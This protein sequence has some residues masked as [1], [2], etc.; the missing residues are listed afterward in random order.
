MKIKPVS[1]RGVT[2]QICYTDHWG[3][4][5]NS[6]NAHPSWFTFE[7]EEQVRNTKWLIEKGDCVF[8]VGACFGSYTL[9]A[10]AAGAEHVVSW[11]PQAIKGDSL[12][13]GDYLF[14]SLK[15]N[16]WESKCEICRFGL[17]DRDGWLNEVTQEFSESE[18]SHAGDVL[19]DDVIKVVSMDNWIAPKLD[20]YQKHFKKFWLKIDVEGAEIE[21]LKGAM[22]TISVLKPSVLVENHID[23]R[24]TIEQ[25]VRELMLGIGYR[26]VDTTKYHSISHS[27]YAIS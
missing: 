24:S 1:F 13:D 10:L 11:T 27:L 21:V 2:F 25:E 8:D 9:T 17:Y 14:A 12:S 3:D 20:W 22:N 19:T 6:R 23:K 7:D 5:K 15:L 4:N 16:G 18:I 26:E